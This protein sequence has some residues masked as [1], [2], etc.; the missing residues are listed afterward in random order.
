MPGVRAGDRARC[1]GARLALVLRRCLRDSRRELEPRPMN[2]YRMTD[3]AAGGGAGVPGQTVESVSRLPA[4]PLRRLVG[5]YSGYR[6]AGLPPAM[7]RGLPSPY[8]T[9]IFTFGDPLCVTAH[10]D[11]RQPGGTYD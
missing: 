2:A 1:R 4:P 5:W 7:R 10:P 11:P 9:V 8:L 6:S 3:G